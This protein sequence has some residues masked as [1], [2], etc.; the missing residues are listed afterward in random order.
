[1]GQMIPMSRTTEVL[2][3][4]RSDPSRAHQDGRRIGDGETGARP[5]PSIRQWRAMSL[6]AHTLTALMTLAWCSTPFGVAATPGL[7]ARRSRN[8]SSAAQ[9]AASAL[10]V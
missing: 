3:G 10:R 4:Y 2:R 9:L 7:A 1:M 8:G 5:T 6:V